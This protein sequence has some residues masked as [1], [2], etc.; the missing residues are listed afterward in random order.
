M[1]AIRIL[2]LTMG[3]LAHG[4]AE[5]AGVRHAR[6][7]SSE[8]AADSVMPAGL[9]WF[10]LV[11]SEPITSDLSGASLVASDGRTTALATAGDARDVHALVAPVPPLD[12]GTYRMDWR[13]VSADGHPVKGSFSFR[14]GARTAA[15]SVR[16]TQGTPPTAPQPIGT[17]GDATA[18]V[19]IAGA[20]LI[21]ALLR[22]AGLGALMAL[23]GLLAFSSWIAPDPHHGSRRLALGLAVA[24]PVL[25]AGHL[26]AWLINVSPAQTL[27]AGT[28]ITTLGTALGRMEALRV[29]LAILACCALA[30]VRRER[31]ALVFATA[32]LIVSSAIGHP[33]AIAPALAIPSKALHL[34]GVALWLGGLLWLVTADRSDPD[35]FLRKAGRVSSIALVAVIVVAASGLVQT[36]LFLP[37]IADIVRS[38]YG[39]GVL[40]KVAGLLVLVLLGA[41]H[42]YRVMPRL[43]DAPACVRM[44]RSVTREVAVMAVIVLL[45]GMLAYIPPPSEEGP[46]PARAVSR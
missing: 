15:D 43:V 46:D 10:R 24:A 13:I 3:L 8:P 41:H 26:I 2:A 25:L 44:A 34:L 27:D 7:V 36:V 18:G 20:P 6:L 23:A 22:G 33:A 31:L 12:A 28:A 38:A 30:L 42:R 17:A 21:P 19:G 37:E 45:G 35:G 39:I 32:S 14:V 9:T 40:A 11:F 29:G 1:I 16:A 4:A 5:G